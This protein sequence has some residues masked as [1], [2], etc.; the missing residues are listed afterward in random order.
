MIDFPMI[1][2]LFSQKFSSFSSNG[3]TIYLVKTCQSKIRLILR[4]ECMNI[5]LQRKTPFFSVKSKKPL[6]ISRKNST[7]YW[8]WFHGKKDDKLLQHSVVRQE[9]LHFKKKNREIKYNS[10]GKK[11]LWRNFCQKIVG[12]KFS[13]FHTVFNCLNCY[14][15][16]IKNYG[17]LDSTIQNGYAEQKN[18]A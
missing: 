14:Q 17:I 10:L 16:H 3:F 11:L 13:N 18:M 6:L 15:F 4:K 9:N 8:K 2:V 12:E 7:I 1:I 5:F